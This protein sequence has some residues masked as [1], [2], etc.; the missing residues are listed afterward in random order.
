MT[1]V[2]KIYHHSQSEQYTQQKEVDLLVPRRLLDSLLLRKSCFFGGK[3][4]PI[5]NIASNPYHLL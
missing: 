3:Y 4:A 2:G 1:K 5:R